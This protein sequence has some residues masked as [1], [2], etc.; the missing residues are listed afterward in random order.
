V[1]IAGHFAL[2]GR[3]RLAKRLQNADSTDSYAATFLTLVWN[4]WQSG[5]ANARSYILGL[6]Y[7]LDVIGGG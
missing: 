3:R 6:S 4:A 5:D 2:V 7:Q 1:S